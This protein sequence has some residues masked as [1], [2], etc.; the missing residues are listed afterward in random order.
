MM[1]SL[2]KTH[3]RYLS[4][5]SYIEPHS[6]RKSLR[7]NTVPG[8]PHN[9]QWPRS[10]LVVRR[11]HCP[12]VWCYL[13]GYLK[14]HCKLRNAHFQMLMMDYEIF[15]GSSFSAVFEMEPCKS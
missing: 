14:H 9:S 6:W 13:M 12:K 8:L 15:F 10:D 1:R 3:A 4:P 2:M 5:L 11:F 7:A